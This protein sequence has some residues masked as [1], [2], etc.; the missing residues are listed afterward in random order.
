MA[1]AQV[2]VFVMLPLPGS[3]PSLLDQVPHRPFDPWVRH[4]KALG[5][6]VCLID[7]PFRN[8]WR[9][10]TKNDQLG[11]FYRSFDLFASP[12]SCLIWL[13]RHSGRK[14][15]GQLENARDVFRYH[16]ENNCMCTGP[17]EDECQAISDA[18]LH[19]IKLLELWEGLGLDSIEG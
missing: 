14:L 10:L 8:F 6:S 2:Q 9:E 1:S 5:L 17:H 12:A 7:P 15:K 3:P 13:A 4:A 16:Y 19:T 11:A 18:L